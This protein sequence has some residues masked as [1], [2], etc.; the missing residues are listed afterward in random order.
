[1]KIP[2]NVIS[3]FKEDAVKRGY[4]REQSR[5]YVYDRSKVYKESAK[6]NQF[7][8]G[9]T[10]VGVAG[11][12][13][14]DIDKLTKQGTKMK[15][16]VIDTVTNQFKP[17]TNELDKVVKKMKFDDGFIKSIVKGFANGIELSYRSIIGACK[18]IPKPLAIVSGS[19]LAL[20]SLIYMSENIK[21]DAK[22]DT[23]KYLKNEQ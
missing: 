10:L 15:T 19:L 5:E 12:M 8:F 18:S 7:I 17:W 16:A 11:K 20:S 3:V 22:H 14:A 23:I 2:P 1:M 13:I 9:G 21:V 6:V 4:D